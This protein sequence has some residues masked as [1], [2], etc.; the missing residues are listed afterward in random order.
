LRGFR[1]SGEG[2]MVLVAGEAGGGKT[3]FL[4]WF[5]ESQGGSLRVLWGA[6][7][8]LLTPRPLGPLFD[9]AEAVGGGL[10]ELVIHGAL[11]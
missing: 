8:P 2:R 9:V 5:C 6:C 10:G 7:E 1:A 11:R 4:R 3:A